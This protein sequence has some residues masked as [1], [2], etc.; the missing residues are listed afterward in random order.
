MTVGLVMIVRNEAAILPRLAESLRGQIDNFTICDTGSTDD[1]LSVIDRV[2]DWCPG[3]VISHEFDGFGP[4]RTVALREA[5]RHTDWMLHMDADETFHGDIGKVTITDGDD[6]IEAEQ[7]NGD[8]RFWLPRLLRSN[9]G[10]ESRGRAHEYYTSPVANPPTY[11]NAF[12][13]EHHG[14]GGSRPQKFE[15]DGGLL[16]EDWR[17]EPNPRTAFYLGRTYEDGGNVPEAV[18]WYRTRIKMPGWDQEDFY[19]RYCLG[20][21]LLALG[22]HEEGCGHLWGSWGMQRQRAEPLV[23]LAE[24][25]RQTEQL[26]LAYQAAELAF[27]WCNALPGNR[28]PRH[29]GLFTDTTATSWRAAYEQSISAWYIGNKERGKSLTM[30]LLEQDLPEPYRSSVQSNRGFYD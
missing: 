22:A 18:N 4:S 12:H 29:D 10:W 26:F 9:R 2:F 3:A 17:E 24:H 6:C 27:T 14:D 13:V 16:L 21:C 30:W 7:Y 1:T 8:L 5:E 25:Y 15:R 20:R 19:A 11:T 23:A 28:L